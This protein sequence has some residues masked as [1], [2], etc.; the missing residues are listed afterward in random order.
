MVFAQE[1]AG[2]LGIE[3]LLTGMHDCRRRMQT[4]VRG[5]WFGDGGQ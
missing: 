2:N 5:R 3:R 1:G 4:L